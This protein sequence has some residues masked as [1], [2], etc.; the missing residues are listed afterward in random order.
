[1]TLK[2]LFTVLTLASCTLFGFTACDDEDYAPITLEV[3]SGEGHL[4]KNVLQLDAFSLGESFLIV[5]GNGRYVIDNQSKDIV[6]YRYDGHALTFI[7]VGIGKATVIIGD[8]AGNRMTLTIEVKNHTDIY[9]V[10]DLEAKAYGR[11][12][13]MGDVENL[14]RQIVNESLVKIGGDIVLTYTNQEQT[15][16]SITIHPTPSG[17]PVSGIFRQEKKFDEAKVPYW[18]FTITLAD[19]RIVVWQL[20]NYQTEEGTK[21]LLQENVL[22]TYKGKYPLLE[23]A[24]LTYKVTF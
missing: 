21:M 16:G 14:E 23:K 15:L 6:D 10:F 22:D 7:P 12:M 4:D 24:S 17:R 18:E 5:G 3:L 1:M 8:H 19:N 20:Q 2:H 13:T 11:N 9:K